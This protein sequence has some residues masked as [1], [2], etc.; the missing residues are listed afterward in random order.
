M[1]K[2][3]A[4]SEDQQ[5]FGLVFTDPS[6]GIRCLLGI[7]DTSEEAFRLGQEGSRQTMMI[8]PEV[9]TWDRR[10]YEEYDWVYQK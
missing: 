1:Y 8:R 2:E 5:G 10:N 4:F 9:V 3:L 6:T 7:F